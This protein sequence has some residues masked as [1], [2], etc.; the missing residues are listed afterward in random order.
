MA[1][2]LRLVPTDPPPIDEAADRDD[3]TLGGKFAAIL[4]EIHRALRQGRGQATESSLG[5]VI[6]H[7]AALVDDYD[8]VQMPS[9]RT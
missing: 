2:Q 1:P 9:G 6:L 3:G 4:D 7:L 8:G 5:G